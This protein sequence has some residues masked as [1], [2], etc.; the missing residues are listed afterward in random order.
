G[1]SPTAAAGADTPQ[2][3]G[4]YGSYMSTVANY[5]TV[6]NY[7]DGYNNAG[8]TVYDRLLTATLDSRGYVLQA[9]ES[10]ELQDE[11]TVVFKLVPGMKTHNKA[12]VNGRPITAEDIVITQQYVTDL[13]N[14]ENA[15]FQR[16]R[17]VGV[18]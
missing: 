15:G 6:A 10:V 9:A 7:H 4:T 2:R 17:L 14:A 3:G 1:A 18:E 12:P 8:V 5:N 13:T 16:T 11:V